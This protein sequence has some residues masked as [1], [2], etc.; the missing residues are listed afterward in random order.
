MRHRARLLYIRVIAGLGAN[1]QLVVSLGLG[2]H[3]NRA[4]SA[5]V[6]GLGGVIADGVLLTDI[7]RYLPGNG[8]HLV[9]VFGKKGNTASLIRQQLERSFGAMG[10]PAAAG[11]VVEQTYRVNDRPLQV[12]DAAHR[13]FQRGA[14]SIVFS[15]RDDQQNLLGTLGVLGQVIGRGHDGVVQGGAALGIDM[16]EA[17]TQL[18]HVG[19]EILIDV[20]LVGKVDH[21]ALIVRIGVVDQIEGSSIHRLAL[22]AHGAGVVYQNSQ[23]YGNVLVQERSDGLLYPVL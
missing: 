6:D 14:R 20:G 19:S 1:D 18:V 12:L 23:R 7:L 5:L 22:G 3:V 9:Q 10:L 15:I 13:F 17:V 4:K 21:E 2:L 11:V 8:V 16:R